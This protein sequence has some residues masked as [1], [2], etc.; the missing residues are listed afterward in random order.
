[1]LPAVA[2]VDAIVALSGGD[3]KPGIKWVN[4]ILLSGRKVAGVLTTTQ[5][6]GDRLEYVVLGIGLNITVAP[7]VPGNPFVPEVGCLR[8]FSPTAQLTLAE[9]NRVVLDAVARRY[10]EMLRFGPGLLFS[11]YRGASVVLGREVL[12]WEE[13]LD[14]SQALESWP[15][16]VARGVVTDIAPDLGLK[17]TGLA[18]PV[19]KGRLA[20]AEVFEAFRG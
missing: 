7:A 4:D 18:D 9:V 15:P 17:L 10:Q 2:V 13:G 8:E 3:L 1:M 11:A 16:P 19:T 14:A 6:Q 12:V 20:L 5:T